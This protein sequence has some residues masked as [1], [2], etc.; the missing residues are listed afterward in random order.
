MRRK[1]VSEQSERIK[2]R[3]QLMHE[4]FEA[5]RAARDQ[6]ITEQGGEL[7]ALRAAVE[8][9]IKNNEE[10]GEDAVPIGALRFALARTAKGLPA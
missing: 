9:L 2:D 7:A 10:L 3:T 8:R 6:E 1:P 4:S 5:G